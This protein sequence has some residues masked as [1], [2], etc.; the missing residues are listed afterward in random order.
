MFPDQNNFSFC[1]HIFCFLSFHS[2]RGEC[3]HLALVATSYKMQHPKEK[4]TLFLLKNWSQIFRG[5]KL[6]HACQ[7]VNPCRRTQPQPCSAYT[8]SPAKAVLRNCHAPSHPSRYSSSLLL[9][10][11]SPLYSSPQSRNAALGPCPT[12][13]APASG[14]VHNEGSQNRVAATNR[15][16]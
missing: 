8:R 12:Q 16:S 11:I 3:F 5:M 6:N 15:C 13:S 2:G 10:F 4:N 9:P 7:T 14:S 1:L